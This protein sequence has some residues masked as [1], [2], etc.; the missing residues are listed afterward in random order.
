MN[1][2]NPLSTSNRVFLTLVVVGAMALAA[3]VPA[4]RP[5]E[6]KQ[7]A[8]AGP[9]QALS[10]ALAT[11]G[12]TQPAETSLPLSNVTGVGR[13]HAALPAPIRGRAGAA[14]L[15]QAVEVGGA[16]DSIVGY[17]VIFGSRTA[18]INPQTE[19]K[20]DLTVGLVVTVR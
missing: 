2:R 8:G 9:T 5:G 7:A 20:F 18:V 19:V 6:R 17:I 1:G 15:G 14:V 4:A 16:I 10:T 3:C 13:T 12:S 11:H